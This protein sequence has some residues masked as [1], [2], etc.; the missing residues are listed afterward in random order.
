KEKETVAAQ[1]EALRALDEA[2]SRVFANISHEFR[3]PLTLILGPLEDVREGVR[4][5]IPEAAA[6]SVASAIRNGRRLLRLVNQLLDVSRLEAGRL[7]LEARPLD[8][9]A[10]VRHLAQV[11]APFAERKHITFR[12]EVPEHP[13]TAFLDPEQFEKVLANLLGNAFKFT[14]EGGTVSVRLGTEA[15]ADG[16]V[17]FVL[18]VQDDG[19]GIAPE[20]L[21]H[22]FDRFYQADASSTRQQPGTGI[23]LALV[24]NL[25]E[26]HGGAI[27]VESTLGEGA[28]FT[29]RV[30]LGRAHLRDEDVVEA[31]PFEAAW[32]VEQDATLLL[33]EIRPA[34]TPDK[35]DAKADEADA[36]ATTVLVVDDNPDVRAYVRSHLAARYRVL[37]AADG[38]EALAATRAH[39]PDLVVS[40]VM[41]PK[42]DGFGLCRAIKTDPEVD[43]I[44]VILL[45]A[46]ASFESKLEGLEGGADAYLTKP[47]EVR[48]LA[49]RVENLIASRQ[50]LKAHF[51]GGGGDVP[52][53]NGAA[54]PLEEG[55]DPFTAEVQAVIA[56]RL[57]EDDFGID[58]LAADLGMGRTTL[59]RRIKDAFGGAPMELVWQMRLERAAALLQQQE[60]TVSEVAYGVGFKS[61]AHFSRRFRAAYGTTPVAYAAEHAG[62]V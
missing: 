15:E 58:A 59:Y 10:F 26:L 62:S 18:T 1:A 54:P 34:P 41:M 60:G 53:G 49:V 25:V 48:E 50:R 16:P 4:G 52:Q 29:V 24:K 8:T 11:F 51:A 23:G 57:S 40:D 19:P 13:V 35:P 36:D 20:H 43:F 56:A 61:V 3:T 55:A 47:F 33:D 31:D 14:P 27:D 21:P 46:K 44:P 30:P 12:V 9:A 7:T 37:E 38:E 32:Y 17:A 28:S 22:L 2:K 42:L 5:A 45:T 6:Q 39:L